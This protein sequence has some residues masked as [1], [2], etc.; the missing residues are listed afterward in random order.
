MGCVV[1]HGEGA[2]A[3]IGGVGHGGR[4]Q[5]GKSDVIAR[6]MTVRMTT[7]QATGTRTLKLRHDGEGAG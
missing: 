7:A 2:S 3:R 6:T 4:E 1:L 5:V